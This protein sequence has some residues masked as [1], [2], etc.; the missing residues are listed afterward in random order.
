MSVEPRLRHSRRH[1]P[2]SIVTLV[3][4]SGVSA[5]CMNVFLPSLPNMTEYFG[6][7]YRVMQLSVALF[8]ACS[9]VLQLVIGPL[10]DKWGRRPVILG[11]LGLFALATLGCILAPTA[12]IF[13]TFR[14]GQAVIAVAMVLS[15]AAVRDQYS[16][17][18]AAS[19]LGY[20]T[21]G[22]A[23]IPMIGPAIGGML[24]ELFGWQ[25]NFW[26]L[27][28]LGLG[29]LALAWFDFGE[30]ATAS[31]LSLLQQFRQYPE[32]LRSPRFWGYSLASAFSSGAFFAFL[33]GAPFVGT[34]V[35]DLAPGRLGFYFG[36]PA[37]GYFLGNFLSGRFAARVGANRMILAG[38]LSLGAGIAMALLANLTG[39]SSAE[40]FFFFM[41]FIGIGNGLANPSAMAGSMSVRPHLAGT[42]A[43][44][45][46]AIML[47]GGAG[48]SALAG[49]MLTPE[50][51]AL[52]LLILMLVTSVLCVASILMVIA[53][54]RQIG[55]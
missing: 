9:A 12:E 21:M 49:A 4:L 22:I 20:V 43:G 19:M 16:Q 52:P 53:R 36:I 33:G 40:A 3:L 45:S 27:L 13:L 46:G 50:S 29:G 6:T 32:L 14:M 35:Y 48:F 5:L 39:Q 10:A 1:T 8:L 24:D 41:A 30:T 23:V 51:G 55:L 31:G 47:G 2:P 17:D 28:G 11:G 38:G 25:A 37:I 42:A 15:R 44:L 26:L 7:E 18:Q 34:D 54:D